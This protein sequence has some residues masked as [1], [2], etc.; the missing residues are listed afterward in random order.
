ML[1]RRG[2]PELTMDLYKEVF[3]FPVVEYYR[4]IGF[5]FN[6]ESFNDLSVEF[7]DAYNQAL[8][9][10]PLARGARK[11]LNYF[12]D[13][14]KRNI[15]ISAMKHDMLVNSVSQKRLIGYFSDILGIDDIY[16]AGKSKVAREYVED[17][18]IDVSDV[19]F[20]GDT[21]HDFEVAQEIGC[22]CIL[23]AN[24][25][26]SEKRLRATGVEVVRSLKNL[27]FE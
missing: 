19:V 21:T 26:Q 16:A 12:C 13:A 27:L 14:G 11:V 10:A 4:E 3:E 22:R 20:I 7:I 9:S 2:L 17:N 5:D 15:I 1:V 25:H 24:G 23:V 8:G 18:D 6:R